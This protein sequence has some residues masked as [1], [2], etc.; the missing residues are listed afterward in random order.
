MI[1]HGGVPLAV[2]LERL[3]RTTTKTLGAH[4]EDVGRLAVVRHPVAGG[5][6]LMRVW[7]WADWAHEHGGEFGHALGDTGIDAVAQYRTGQW[8]AIQVKTRFGDN[9]NVSWDEL[10]TFVAK[11]SRPPFDSPLLILLGDAALG[12]TARREL[13]D[14]VELWTSPEIAAAEGHELWPATHAEV[15]TLLRR[16]R[17]PRPAPKQLRE[18]QDEAVAE[19]LTTFEHQARAQLI[20][21]CG[22]GKTV[23]THAVA[24]SVHAQLVLVLA[25]SLALLKQLIEAYAW[26][27]SGRLR[28]IAVCSDETV[29]RRRE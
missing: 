19:V 1:R 20:M 26:Q 11:S 8:R 21:A 22:T 13:S 27:Y 12:P 4:G 14:D 7:R 25:P 17:P 2:L 29:T 23:T 5:P 3:D 16:Q 6:D 10:S 18:H 28:A 24:T 9:S 15:C